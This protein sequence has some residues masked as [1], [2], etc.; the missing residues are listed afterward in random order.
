MVAIFII[1]RHKIEQNRCERTPKEQQ[2]GRGTVWHILTHDQV[3][4]EYKISTNSETI[5]VFDN[6]YAF[7]RSE[8]QDSRP[9]PSTW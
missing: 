5:K 2:S 8:M 4:N 1:D 9:V 6:I 7:C 3:G